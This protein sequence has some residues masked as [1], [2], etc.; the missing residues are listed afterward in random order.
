MSKPKPTLP[1]VEYVDDG[2]DKQAAMECGLPYRFWMLTRWPKN[3]R[4]ESGEICYVYGT[5]TSAS[6][7]FKANDRPVLERIWSVIKN[8]YISPETIQSGNWVL[9]E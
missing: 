7:T 1:V 9:Y 2:L 6:F 3:F 5:G 4:K 8:Y